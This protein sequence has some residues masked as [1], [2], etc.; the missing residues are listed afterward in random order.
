MVTYAIKELAGI[1]FLAFLFF[2]TGRFLD[3]GLAVKVAD[4]AQRRLFFVGL[5]MVAWI[6]F[7][8][9]LAVAQLLYPTVLI[10][11]MALCV[12]G[13]LALFRQEWPAALRTGVRL[14]PRLSPAA[15]VVLLAMG[16]VLLFQLVQALS[17][18]IAPDSQNYHL[19][20]PR[21]YLLHHGFCYLPF[22]PTSNWP[23]NIEMLFL[24]AMV[25]ADY[26]QTN[27]MHLLCTGLTLAALYL[28]GRERAGRFA[29]L[30]AAFFFLVNEVVR[31]I[32][33][34]AYPELG[35]TLFFFLSFW[36]VAKSLDEPEFEKRHL[37]VAGIFA[38]AMAGCKLNAFVGG[39]ALGV[40]Y[41]TARLGAGHFRRSL[42]RLLLYFGAP[43]VCL[44]APWLIKSAVMTGNPVYPFLYRVFG[45]VEWT[46]ALSDDFVKTHLA[47]GMGHKPLD[48]LLLPFHVIWNGGYDFQHFFGVIDKSWIAVLPLTAIFGFRLP[49]VRRALFAALIYFG[50][51]GLGTQQMRHLIPVL[52]LL[53]AAAAM[54]LADW[55]SRIPRRRVAAVLKPVFLL[56]AAVYLVYVVDLDASTWGSPAAGR[57][58]RQ[59]EPDFDSFDKFVNERLPPNARILYPELTPFFWYGLTLDR[60]IVA[61]NL[62]ATPQI[63]RLLLFGQNDAAIYDKLRHEKFTH[64]LTETG[65]KCGQNPPAFCALVKNPQYVKDVFHNGAF[66]LYEL[67]PP[68]EE[69]PVVPLTAAL[70]RPQ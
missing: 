23:L 27:L 57:Q 65:K 64:V 66:T 16:S 25:V 43:S 50:A 22:R 19:F 20:V 7:I 3:R 68:P 48:L 60:D 35:M 56:G 41:L 2:A 32:C 17:T 13:Y 28:F 59:R 55:F 67:L 39:V 1:L 51:W 10:V 53:A 34:L 26:V 54:T 44:L 11:A 36:F 33:S 9:L 38:G 12:A 58:F 14:P 5:G 70:L 61:T 46:A 40:V 52:P 69:R 31:W 49:V 42:G 63:H 8:F 6:Y 37:L 4:S 15:A 21:R 62:V 18:H 29:G 30:L 47:M 45:G 24:L